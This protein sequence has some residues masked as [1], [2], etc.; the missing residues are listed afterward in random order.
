MRGR[1]DFAFDSPK[2][3]TI[4]S[5]SSV[6]EKARRPGSHNGHMGVDVKVPVGAATAVVGG[7]SPTAS[8]AVV[9]GAATATATARAEISGVVI[10][11]DGTVRET[12]GGPNDTATKRFR[13]FTLPDRTTVTGWVVR[14]VIVGAVRELIRHYFDL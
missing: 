9:V 11:A 8:V 13:V 2:P 14:G 4:G 12:F 6:D 3:V 10:T 1:A 7:F 5:T